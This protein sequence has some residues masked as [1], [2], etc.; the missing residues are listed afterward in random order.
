MQ[1]R[2]TGKRIS[3]TLTL[4]LA[5]AGAQAVDSRHSA[6]ALCVAA[7]ERNV[8]SGLHQNP[9]DQER[10]QWLRRLESAYAHMGDAYLDGLSGDAG[11]ALL[12]DAESAVASWP[13]VRLEAQARSC[14]QQGIILLEHAPGW[15]R[16]LMRRSAQRLLERELAKLAPPRVQ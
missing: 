12:R 5:S 10:Q 4:L 1:M 8:K 3:L 14:E 2:P 6:T 15:Q 9:S 13:P 7:I 16:M 11:K